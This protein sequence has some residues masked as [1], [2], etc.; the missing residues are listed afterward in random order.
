MIICHLVEISTKK[1]LHF[2]RYVTFFGRNF[3]QV[4][5]YHPFFLVLNFI[6]LHLVMHLLLVVVMKMIW[7][8][9]TF[10]ISFLEQMIANGRIWDLLLH[11]HLDL[12]LF[13]KASIYFQW[14]A[15]LGF[16]SSKRI[17]RIESL[18]KCFISKIFNSIQL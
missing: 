15:N 13:L 14:W 17:R 9:F 5:S 11:L 7:N 2:L 8:M 3:Y 1:K 12:D 16:C 10:A 6:N 18:A 4:T